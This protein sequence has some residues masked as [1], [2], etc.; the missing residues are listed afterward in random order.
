[1]KTYLRSGKLSEALLQNPDETLGVYRREHRT[2]M[3][4]GKLYHQVRHSQVIAMTA[5]AVPHPVLEGNLGGWSVVVKRVQLVQTLPG[6]CR[7][8][9]LQLLLR[10][11]CKI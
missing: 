11:F 10:Q 2:V 6:L 3:T 7:W 9:S 1:M 4:R 5:S 8:V